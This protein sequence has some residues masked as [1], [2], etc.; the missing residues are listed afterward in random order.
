M[1]YV[2]TG[3]AGWF[4]YILFATR[5]S[6]DCWRTVAEEWIQ[7]EVKDEESIWTSSLAYISEGGG[8]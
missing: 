4:H 1:L 5:D 8:D 3:T 2:C 7:E 6:Q